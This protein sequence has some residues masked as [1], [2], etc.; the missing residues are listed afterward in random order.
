MKKKL[1]RYLYHGDEI[2]V[3]STEVTY[4]SK[5]TLSCV[6]H[7]FLDRPTKLVV[8]VTLKTNDPAKLAS[9]GLFVDGAA[10]PA[11][12]K[13]SSL[14][15]YGL[16]VGD[17]DPGG[18]AEGIHTLDLKLKTAGGTCYNQ[19]FEVYYEIPSN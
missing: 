7:P 18:W 6:I 9:L 12:E 11:F 14:T 15:G 4:E 1:R 5:K 8:A 3:S 13:T 2:E 10:S 19:L 17:I 16:Q